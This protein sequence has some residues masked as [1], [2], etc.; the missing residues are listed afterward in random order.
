MVPESDEFVP[1]PHVFKHRE[2]RAIL[3]FSSSKENQEIA[4]QAGAELSVGPEMV[5][6]ILKGQ[7]RIDDYDF[8]V[9]HSD[10]MGLMNSLRGLLKSR[11]PTIL[12]GT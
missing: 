8:C 9:A 10:M 5:K 12:N 6:K 4:L 1:I 2:K 7:F 11:F 3:A